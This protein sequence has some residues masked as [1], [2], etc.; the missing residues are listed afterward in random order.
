VLTVDVVDFAALAL[1]VARADSAVEPGTGADGQL[2]ER[3][4]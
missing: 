2:S 3:V 1:E 4:A